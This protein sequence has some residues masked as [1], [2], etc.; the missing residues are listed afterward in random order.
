MINVGGL[1]MVKSG[2]DWKPYFDREVSSIQLQSLYL[3]LHNEGVV[4]RNAFYT[5]VDNVINELLYNEY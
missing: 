5:Y 1:M 2:D 4:K 3:F